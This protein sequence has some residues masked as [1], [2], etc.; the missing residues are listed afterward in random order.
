MSDSLQPHGLYPA[1]PL[2]PWDSPGKNTELPFPP[3]RE[4]PYPGIERGSPAFPILAGRFFTTEPP[5]KPQNLFVKLSYLILL[6]LLF[7]ISLE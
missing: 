4:L 5:E 7:K 1:R 2:C 3:L 6:I